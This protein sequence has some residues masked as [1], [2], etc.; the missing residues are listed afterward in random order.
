MTQ[1]QFT[2]FVTANPDVTTTGYGL[3]YFFNKDTPKYQE[4]WDYERAELYTLYPM[5]CHCLN[6]LATDPVLAPH[7]TTL[8]FKRD[9]ERWLNAKGISNHYIPQGVF[10]LA[11][12]SVGYTIAKLDEGGLNAFLK[13]Q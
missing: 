13:K 9:V 1:S 5:Y 3:D 6:W 2:A 12:L 8:E 10:I 4:R 7:R 11:A